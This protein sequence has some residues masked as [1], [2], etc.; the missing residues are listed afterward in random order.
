MFLNTLFTWIMNVLNTCCIPWHSCHIFQPEL[1]NCIM[2][3]KGFRKFNPLMRT[4]T[5]DTM[6]L[7]WKHISQ[8]HVLCIK[9]SLLNPRGGCIVE[10]KNN[11]CAMP[12]DEYP[13]CNFLGHNKGE[14]NKVIGLSLFS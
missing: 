1:L 12:L 7:K 4:N 13:I 5:F 10:V 11:V 3:L 14:M 8:I 2:V 9:E 6:S